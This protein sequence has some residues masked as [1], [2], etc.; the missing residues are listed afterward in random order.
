VKYTVLLL[1]FL[2]ALPLVAGEP[3]ETGAPAAWSPKAAANY[4]DTRET[5]WQTWPRAQRDHETS[6]VSC[7]SVLPYALSRSAL[8]RELGEQAPTA[9]ERTMLQYIEKRVRLW[10]EVE[11]FYKSSA[12]DPNKAV[13][14]RGTEAVL[15]A[16]ILASYDA[17]KGH[18]SDITRAA[19]DNVWTL[20]VPSGAK[21]GAW[22]W[23]NFHYSPWESDESQYWGATMAALAVGTAPDG[24]RDD[25][26]IQKN[27]ELLRG[28]LRRDYAAQ[29]LVNKVALLWA[30][31]RLPGLLT[32][33]ERGAL[34]QPLFTKQN[35]DGG[36]SLGTL[37]EFKRRD[38]TPL[39]VK[40][41]GYATGLTVLA[42][43]EAGLAAKQPAFEAA[44]AWLKAN[45]DKTEGFWPGWSVNKE[46]DPASEIGR[47]MNDAGTAYAIM[48]IE[49]SR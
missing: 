31:S 7:H 4:L 41:D 36:W 17:G 28:Y 44:L 15:N 43:E 16:L 38:D 46:R 37:G 2:T 3:A 19:F 30:S 34:M 24:Y 9:A 6:C 1:C 21:G 32:D 14:S 35:A 18:V 11:S 27:L 10:N 22:V 40:S 23:L 25:P 49:K 39:P 26:K 12:T 8:R 42:F 5:W 47:F 45:Q 33:A 29:P 20:Q 13:E 48:A